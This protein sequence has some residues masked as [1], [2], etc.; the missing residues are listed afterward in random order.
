M[1]RLFLSPDKLKDGTGWGSTNDQ[2][3]K[4]MIIFSRAVQAVRGR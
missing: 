4:T 3:P 1:A 2:V